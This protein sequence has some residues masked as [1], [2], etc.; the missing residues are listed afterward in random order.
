MLSY[1]EKIADSYK[2]PEVSNR[3]QAIFETGIKLA[4]IFHQ[5][6][7]TPICWDETIQTKIA[8]GI[9]ASIKCQ[10]FVKEV[11]IAFK[12]LDEFEEEKFSKSHEYDYTVISGRNLIAEVELSY[13][14]WSIVGRLEWIEQLKYPLMYM[15]SIKKISD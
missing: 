11:H 2:I 6:S 8:E 4:A 1:M 3:D 7:G 14:E 9:I 10:P 13:K 15:K 12:A 5:F